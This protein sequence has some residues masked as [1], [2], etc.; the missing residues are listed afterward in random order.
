MKGAAFDLAQTRVSLDAF[1]GVIDAVYIRGLAHAREREY[2]AA[3]LDFQS[4]VD[5]P[6]IVL[7]DITGALAHLQLARALAGA[8]QTEKAK[9]SYRRFLEI[10]KDADRDIPLLQEVKAEFAR[11]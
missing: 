3:A 6:G 8:G 1:Y 10:W 4:V 7:S 11:L 5:H 9:A 2:G